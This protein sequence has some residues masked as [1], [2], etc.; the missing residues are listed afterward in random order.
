M[1]IY[2][3]KITIKMYV[4]YS[5]CIYKYISE[6]ESHPLLKK[7][8]YKVLCKDSSKAQCHTLIKLFYFFL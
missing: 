7:V 6:N 3:T 5:I 2:K 1:I 4:F 8:V